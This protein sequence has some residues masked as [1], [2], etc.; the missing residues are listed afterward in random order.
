MMFPLLYGIGAGSRTNPA[1]SYANTYGTGD[2]TASITITSSDQ[3]VDAGILSNLVDGAFGNSSN[4]GVDFGPGSGT[5]SA[6]GEGILI[7]FGSTA[8]KFI[9]EVKIYKDG[10]NFGT[11]W[12]MRGSNDALTFH[13]LTSSAFSLAS[14]ST[15]NTIALDQPNGP[16]DTAGWRYLQLYG[17]STGAIWANNWLTEFEFKIANIS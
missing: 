16:S 14:A 10:G 13:N 7:D 8:V 15:A 17:G 4:D 5:A 1:T 9:D 11:G 6:S 2:R 3:A 12:L